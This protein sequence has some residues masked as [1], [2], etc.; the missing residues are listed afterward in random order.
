MTRDEA[1]QLLQRHIKN[2]N[3]IKHSL[4]AE[5]LMRGLARKFGEDEEKWG[6][7]GFLHDL[8]W[9]ETWDNPNEHSLKAYEI[10]KT[11]D[12]DPEIAEAIRVHNHVHGIAPQTLLEKALYSAEEITGLIVACALVQPDRK[13]ASVTR[14][15]VLKK[16]KS[17]SFAAGVNRELI[18]QVEPML[19]MKL[20]ELVDISL[21]EMKKIA[22][23]LGL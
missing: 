4:A 20:E 2:P 12:I 8:D 9:E 10:L 1:W 23:E 5:A 16:F 18:I 13:L 11:S 6:L 21:E 7:A 22:E 19:G 3:L 17:K 15:S 14:E